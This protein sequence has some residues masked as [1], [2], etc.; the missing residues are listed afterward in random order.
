VAAITHLGIR[1]MLIY[2]AVG[3]SIWFA[4]DASGIH[5]TL[6]GVMLGLMTSTRSWVSDT[7]LHAILDRLVAYPPGDHWSDDSI[8]MED[9]HRA[10]VATIEVL[11]PVERFEIL[12]HPWVIFTVMPL[13][14]LANAGV[15]IS[16]ADINGAVALAIFV[17][18]VVGKPI[19][20]I[21]FSYFALKLGLAIRPFELSWNMLVA[22]SLLTGIG[23]TM[24]LFIAEL[25]FVTDLLN[26]AKLAIL[27]ASGVSAICGL[28]ALAWL[29]SSRRRS[30]E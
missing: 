22:G 8:Y 12:L 13:F 16:L 2:L 9:L 28:L 14:A 11:S 29:T 17:A 23:F 27:G 1:N 4:L 10:N 20:V 5:P 26:S 24:A 21:L 6:A 30:P 25:A 15:P 18:L 3:V 19:G 7:R